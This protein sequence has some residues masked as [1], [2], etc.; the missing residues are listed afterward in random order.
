MCIC[1]HFNEVAQYNPTYVDL[2]IHFC[3]NL[4]A[5]GSGRFY[6]LGVLKAM[7]GTEKENNITYQMIRLFYNNDVSSHIVLLHYIIL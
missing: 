1:I 6:I 3:I 7:A 5:L 2:A 4:S